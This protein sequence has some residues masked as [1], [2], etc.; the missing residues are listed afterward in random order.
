MH[1]HPSVRRPDWTGPL[2]G[3]KWHAPGEQ[4]AVT[5]RDRAHGDPGDRD[6]RDVLLFGAAL[7]RSARLF[8][9]IL[10]LRL[11]SHRRLRRGRDPGFHRALA[12]APAIGASPQVDH[13]RPC[14]RRRGHLGSRS[15]A[16]DP[17]VPQQPTHG[18]HRPHTRSGHQ[19]LSL[20]PAAARQPFRH[21]TVRGSVAA[22]DRTL[23][24]RRWLRDNSLQSALRCARRTAANP[25]G[26]PEPGVSVHFWRRLKHLPPPLFRAWRRDG[27][28]L[29]GC[30]R[31]LTG[32]R[33]IRRL[34]C[35][36]RTIATG[37][38]VSCLHDPPGRTPSAC[39]PT[40][41]GGRDRRLAGHRPGLAGA[42]DCHAANSCS[43]WW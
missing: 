5:R 17:A 42:R 37:A 12:A 4:S 16:P 20:H 28:R 33:P 35:D 41:P 34:V 27:A 1:V 13:H 9:S 18:P 43:G 7:V 40:Q 39:R 38:A 14:R 22:S 25:S 31:A 24:S 26:K 3:F 36:R 19:F 8:K 6:R 10:D 32:A 15:V 11:G 23:L 30:E 29:D 2:A 21:G